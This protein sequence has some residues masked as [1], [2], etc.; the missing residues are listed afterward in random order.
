[1]P[2]AHGLLPAFGDDARRLKKHTQLI[3][4]GIEL[5]QE[6]RFNAKMFA[7]IS[8]TL[9]DAAFGVLPVAAHI[10][11]A[12]GAGRA[13]HGVGPPHD[14]DNQIATHDAATGRRFLTRPSD[15]CPRIKRSL[16]GGGQPYLP[17]MISRSVPQMPNASARTRTL[18]S[19]SGGSG[20][21]SKLMEFN[22]PG[23]TVSARIDDE[24]AGRLP[25]YTRAVL[26]LGSRGRKAACQNVRSDP[27]L[28]WVNSA[29]QT[30]CFGS[31]A[32]LNL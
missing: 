17:L 9:L 32:G 25:D 3:E 30:V 21:S 29:P 13:R 1:M 24:P 19:P 16:P 28:G 8:V 6:I 18:P 31:L 12:C 27:P 5:D 7:A 20:K 22:W 23:W 10:P 26:S 2:D 11:L 14:A 15:S 4:R